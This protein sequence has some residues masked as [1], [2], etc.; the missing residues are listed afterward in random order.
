MC[1]RWTS[2]AAGNIIGH[3][4]LADHRGWGKHTGYIGHDPTSIHYLQSIHLPI[5]GHSGLLE[6]CL[7]ER[8]QTHSTGFHFSSTHTH[9][10]HT[11]QAHTIFICFFFVCFL[12]CEEK[13]KYLE[14]VHASMERKCTLQWLQNIWF[15][16]WNC[17]KPDSGRIISKALLDATTKSTFRSQNK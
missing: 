12:D 5:P 6:L 2:K 17:F 15:L 7:G 9:K 10:Q 3:W 11:E 14:K 13:L 4:N 8:Q 16:T 1:I